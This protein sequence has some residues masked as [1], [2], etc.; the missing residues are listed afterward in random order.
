M[1]GV[2][3]KLDLNEI[4][5]FPGASVP[6]SC[7]LEEEALTNASV[8]GFSEPPRATGEVR[9]TAGAIT[10][11]GELVA[12][13]RCVCDRCGDVFETEKRMALSVPLA[14]DLTDEENADIFPIE[15]N[16][17]D[18]TEVL[19]TVFLLDLETKFLCREDCK[20]LCDRCGANLNRGPCNCGPE[21]D[22]R[23]AVL[24][25]LLDNIE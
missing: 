12:L 4:I 21:V 23:M 24:G 20:G 13:M 18:L 15:E 16:A 6:F 11:T 25:Q 19:E 2:P 1:L 22:P 14:A 8:I 5:E 9:N 3:I 17:I 10:L 7:E